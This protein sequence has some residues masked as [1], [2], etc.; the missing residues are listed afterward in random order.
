MRKSSSQFPSKYRKSHHLNLNDV[1]YLLEIDQ[2]NLSR[3]E[4]RKNPNP[5]ALLGYHILFDL[6]IGNDICQSIFSN[7]K[8]I[9]HRCFR[10]LEI[11]ETKAKTKKNRLRI[12]GVN[13]IIS[14]LI[15]M[16]EGNDKS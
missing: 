1:A 11:I 3:F 12:K 15:E 14:R 5:K 7:S 4:A 6:S 9:I 2:A 16:R 10:L 8:E 13:R